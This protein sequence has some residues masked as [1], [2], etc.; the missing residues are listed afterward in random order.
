MNNLFDKVYC[1]SLPE[2]QDRWNKFIVEYKNATGSNDVTKMWAIPP[3]PEIIKDNADLVLFNYPARTMIGCTLSHIKV[4]SDALFHGYESILVLEDDAFL[5]PES[6]ETVAA[7][8]KEIP[9]DWGILYLG[10]HPT[11]PLIKV[12]ERIAKPTSL[13]WSSWGYAIRRDAMHKVIHKCLDMISHTSYDGILG[14]QA[15]AIQRYVMCPPVLSVHA[16][17]STITNSESDLAELAKPD[18]V[19]FSP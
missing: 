15:E 16:G 17:H 19:K 3:A 5:L 10:G 1:V 13:F 6:V 7:A 11:G 14:K 9:N 4:L 18:W 2:S 12:T 8:L